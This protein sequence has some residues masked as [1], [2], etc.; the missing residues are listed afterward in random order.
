MLRLY[1]PFSQELG[2][3]VK[4]AVGLGAATCAPSLALLL[5][6][7]PQTANAAASTTPIFC[8]GGRR[9][10]VDS[11][12]WT[13]RPSWCASKAWLSARRGYLDGLPLLQGIYRD[14]PTGL[15]EITDYCGVYRYTGLLPDLEQM[16]PWIPARPAVAGI[17]R[18]VADGDGDWPRHFASTRRWR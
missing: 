9:R 17:D 18:A 1:D 7:I 3:W 15:Q 2:E 6:E 8:C 5:H 13:F 11:W 14:Q 4:C 10:S 16:E 12:G